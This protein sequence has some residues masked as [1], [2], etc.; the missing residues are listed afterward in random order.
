MISERDCFQM[1]QYLVWHKFT[2]IYDTS[3]F[4]LH[5]HPA[6]EGLNFGPEVDEQTKN[7]QAIR[8]VCKSQLTKSLKSTIHPDMLLCDWTTSYSGFFQRYVIDEHK[9][10]FPFFHSFSFLV[11]FFGGG[12]DM[13]YPLDPGLLGHRRGSLVWVT[14][15]VPTPEV[16]GSNLK[17][18]PTWESCQLF[19]DD[20]Q[21]TVQ[22]P[23][24][25]EY[26]G[27]LCP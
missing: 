5:P 7:V 24:Q 21:F 2:E 14:Y 26:T 8:Y 20:W 1:E 3:A 22:S 4:M 12:G 16:A 27:F 13:F 23:D 15:S 18:D 17:L 25:L 6:C 19:T 10:C 9:S 11:L